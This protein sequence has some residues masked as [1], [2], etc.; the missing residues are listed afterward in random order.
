M[1]DA[2]WEEPKKGEKILGKA[3]EKN[4]ELCKFEKMLEDSR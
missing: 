4:E 2:I 3:T 1:L